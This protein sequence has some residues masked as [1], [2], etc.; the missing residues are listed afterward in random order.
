MCLYVTVTVKRHS[1][2]LMAKEPGAIGIKLPMSSLDQP[3]ASLHLQNLIFGW[4][5]S[6]GSACPL[7]PLSPL[8]P[9]SND[10]A[11]NFMIMLGHLRK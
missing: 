11:N 2:F 8:P 7:P 1:C 4:I 5:G 3:D 9:P 6:L 10:N